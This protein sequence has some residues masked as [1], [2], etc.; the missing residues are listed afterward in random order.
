V[1][2]GR[3]LVVAG[4]DPAGVSLPLEAVP[5][6]TVL[7]GAP[8]GLATYRG[9]DGR[10][11][12][13]SWARAGATGWTAL[14]V[15]DDAEFSGPLRSASLRAQVLVAALLLI[16]GTGLVVLAPQARGRLE[17]IAL[18][19]DLTGLYNRRGWFAL[20]EA[21]LARAA[22]QDRER[23]LM[24]V[25]LDGL[26]QVNDVLGHR[27]GDR[28]IASRPTVLRDAAQAGD[29][30]GAS[31][32]T[33]SCCC[34]AR[35][36]TPPPAGPACS[37]RS[38]R[39][40]AP[41]AAPFELRLSL[42]C[43]GLVPPGAAD[44]GRTGPAGRRLDVRRQSAR[45]DRHDGVVRV[46]QPRDGTPAGSDPAGAPATAPRGPG[47]PGRGRRRRWVPGR[48]RRRSWCRAASRCW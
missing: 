1:V 25:D 16:A 13:V 42:G 22:R 6:K 40:T 34:S 45:T 38:P 36:A 32:A 30:V 18:H 12:T 15:Q 24:F 19:D 44:P 17:R 7:G 46:P 43:R 31:A 26:K 29:L 35:T 2:D 33:S 5:L 10:D 41:R 39:T 4:E 37:P 21:E 47:S 23:V 20:A 14:T 11:W 27:E 48:R 28:A 9:A 3:G 8:S